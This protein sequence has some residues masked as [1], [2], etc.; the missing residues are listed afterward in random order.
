MFKVGDRV[1]CVD[2][3]AGGKV[4]IRAGQTYI[5]TEVSDCGEFCMVGGGKVDYFQRRFRSVRTFKG[6]KHAT[7]S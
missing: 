7:A 1:E 4:W 6:N 2:D 5:V 3:D